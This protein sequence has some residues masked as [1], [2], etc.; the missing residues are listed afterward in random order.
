MLL[1]PSHVTLKQVGSHSSIKKIYY[2]GEYL[3]E[4]LCGQIDMVNFVAR[5]LPMDVDFVDLHVLL[6]VDHFHFAAMED[7]Y[8]Q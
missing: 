7:H 4:G 5:F 6:I 1:S 3:C 8:F 2:K